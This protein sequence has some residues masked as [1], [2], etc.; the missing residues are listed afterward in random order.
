MPSSRNPPSRVPFGNTLLNTLKEE[1]P[2]PAKT[3]TRRGLL[4]TAGMAVLGLAA[5]CRQT[6]PGATAPS[7]APATAATRVPTATLQPT[8]AATATS[9]PSPTT[10]ARPEPTA[11]ATQVPTPSATTA[12]T[13]EAGAAI[14]VDHNCTNLDRIPAEW[15]ERAKTLTFHYAHTSHGSQII[16]GLALIQAA[17]PQFSAAVRS[18]VDDPYSAPS[19]PDQAGALRIFD[20]TYSGPEDYWATPEGQART[21]ATADTGLFDYSMWSWCGQQSENVVDMVRY[22]LNVLDEFERQYPQMRFIY[23]TG[24][25]DGGSETLQRNNDL[26][27]Q[28][29]REHDKILYDFADIES[30]DPAG[31]YY[32][33]ASDAC[34]WCEDWCA[35]HPEE[36]ADLSGTCEHSHPLMC[37]LKGQAFW[38]LMARLAGWNG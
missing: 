37:K 10:T 12:P 36:C 34:I 16:A 30:Y 1:M 23:M 32:P 13:A 18:N 17:R 27:R 6:S 11:T 29:V 8:L 28:Y 9:A 26:V 7:I 19:L 22:Y 38:W 15:L 14:V 21:R 33:E 5:G 20:E 24:H 2:V 4:V 31:D 35:D 25:T 3:I